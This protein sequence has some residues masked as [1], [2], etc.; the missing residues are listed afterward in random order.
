MREYLYK[1]ILLYGIVF[2]FIGAAI[3][4]SISGYN[5]IRILSTKEVPIRFSLN[6]DYVNAYWKFDE[7]SGNIAHDSSGHGYDGT[8]YGATWT[9]VGLDFDGADDYVDLDTHSEALG[10]NKTD[11]YFVL[12]RFRSTGS[13]MLYSMS[14]TDPARP[15]YNFEL[16]ADGKI[17]VTLGDET[18]LF[19][20][21]TSNTYNDG[22]WYNVEVKFYGSASNPTLEIYVDGV[23]DGTTTKWLCPMLDQDFKTAKIGRKSNAASNFLDGEIDE[24]KIYKNLV[25]SPPSNPTISGQKTGSAGTAYEYSFTSTDA[26]GDQVSYYIKWGDTQTSGWTA[27]QAQGTA[28]KEKHTYANQGTFTIE[29]Q[30]KDDTGLTSGWSTYTVTMPRNKAVDF[31]SLFL[32]FLEQH[33]NILLV[34]K[35]ILGL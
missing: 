20:L 6:D 9:S 33:P 5:N 29:A 15:Y 14:H 16:S 2:L 18:C 7:G 27:F 12:V 21:A 26:D 30:A 19:D 31:N 34:L 23:L 28:Y 13:G 11:D 24:V 1:K 32:R 4:P 25:G 17:S 35:Y 3:L 8:I 22:S 10:M